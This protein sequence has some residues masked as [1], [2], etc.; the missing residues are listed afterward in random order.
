[1]AGF[2]NF[3]WL[4]QYKWLFAVL[5]TGLLVWGIVVIKRAIYGKEYGWLHR[6]LHPVKVTRKGR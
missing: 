4:T 5:M 1:M 3:V 2:E 6:W